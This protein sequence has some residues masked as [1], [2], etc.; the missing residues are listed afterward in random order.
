MEVNLV[1]DVYKEML[2]SDR[3]L[4]VPILGSLS[5]LNLPE[6]LKSSITDAAEVFFLLFFLLLSE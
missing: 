1:V 5:D 3:S 2:Q 6:H 4:L